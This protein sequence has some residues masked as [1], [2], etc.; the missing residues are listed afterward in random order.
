VQTLISQGLAA[1]LFD[2]G[3]QEKTTGRCGLGASNPHRNLQDLK[4]T[5][6]KELQINTTCHGCTTYK[7]TKRE[8]DVSSNT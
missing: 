2:S 7:K 1:M 5:H 4:D 6:P 3:Q 8:E